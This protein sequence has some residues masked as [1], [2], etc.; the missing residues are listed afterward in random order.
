MLKSFLRFCAVGLL[1]GCASLL[2]SSSLSAQSSQAEMSDDQLHV[3]AT[4]PL[5]RA[6]R[7]G[8]V[9][10]ELVITN[11]TSAPITRDLQFYTGNSWDLQ[12]ES[13]ITVRI[14]ANEEQ[15]LQFFL[16]FFGPR[17]GE[18]I[19]MQMRSDNSTSREQIH[20]VESSSSNRSAAPMLV[21][22]SAGWDRLEDF[23]SQTIRS[24]GQ[25]NSESSGA[26][27]LTVTATGILAE[28]LASDWRAYSTLSLVAIDLDA[29]LPD[30]AAMEALVQWA[31]LGG[32]I[33]FFGSTPARA[34]E[35]LANAGVELEERL[36]LPS[37]EDVRV[38]RQGFGRIAVYSAAS[39][40]ER[41]KLDDL[42]VLPGGVFPS[43]FLVLPP[44]LPGVGLPPLS[45]LTVVLIAVALVLGPIQFAQMKKRNAKPWRF[46]Q[47]TPILGIS[48]AIVVLVASVLSQ[49]LG[50]RESVQSVTWLDQGR[51]TASTVAS[52][53]SFSGSL[54]AQRQRYGAEALLVPSSMIS[55]T[56]GSATF[57]VD[58]NDGARLGG[59]FMPTRIPASSAVVAHTSARSG[60]RLERENGE[61]YAVNDLDVALQRLRLVDAEN[62][63]YEPEDPTQDL[64]PG[65]RTRM[66]ATEKL[67][68]VRLREVV[69]LEGIEILSGLTPVDDDSGG[70]NAQQLKHLPGILPPRSWMAEVGESPF[71][72]D[73]GV[74]RTEEHAVHLILGLLEAKE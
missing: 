40:T 50:V 71:L 47:I 44:A 11:Q 42:G 52:R 5:P 13:T 1:V 73:G 31:S 2:A 51:K 49:G 59:F 29:P 18:S 41:P 20:R 27:K 61:L 43:V 74:S 45:L 34:D 53:T 39:R 54:F 16:P 38:F 65:E 48:F 66:V 72:P 17:F 6:M 63:S 23:Q 14:D 32:S 22:T 12:A 19:R 58:L 7:P 3:R 68:D 69:G 46:L 35:L 70:M 4:V 15:R 56:R 37:Y 57:T 30:R 26:T 67:F 64:A 25:D 21:V 24:S 36:Q 33:A 62:I 9:P 60:V 55:G 28:D 10:V 8:W